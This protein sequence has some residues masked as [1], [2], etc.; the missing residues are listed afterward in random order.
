MRLVTGGACAFFVGL[1]YIRSF[2][3]TVVLVSG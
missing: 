3:G 2:E 1:W